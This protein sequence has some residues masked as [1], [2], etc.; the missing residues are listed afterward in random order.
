MPT[1]E[2]FRQLLLDDVAGVR[3]NLDQIWKIAQSLPPGDT[4]TSL[5]MVHQSLAQQSLSL[6][7]TLM[8]MV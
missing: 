1:P 8:E 6:K 3:A 5:E 4:R 2:Q 7:K